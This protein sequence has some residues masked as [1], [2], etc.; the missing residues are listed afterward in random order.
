MIPGIKKKPVICPSINR[1]SAGLSNNLE[2]SHCKYSKKFAKCAKNMLLSFY[3]H[4]GKFN[5]TGI[6]NHRH[7]YF[8]INDA[9]CILFLSDFIHGI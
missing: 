4:T 3:Q 7:S 5:Y 1:S 2:F 8:Q 6:V 9:I